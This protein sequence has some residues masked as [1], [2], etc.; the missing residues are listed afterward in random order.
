MTIITLHTIDKTEGN[1][2]KIACLSGVE[3]ASLS[4]QVEQ[5]KA[6]GK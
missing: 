6:G 2:Q 1:A 3:E 5:I 4:A